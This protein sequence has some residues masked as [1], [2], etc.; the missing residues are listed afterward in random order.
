MPL[1][2]KILT[3]RTI[4]LDLVVVSEVSLGSFA[5]SGIDSSAIV[6]LM[7]RAG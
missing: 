6:V 5:G 3:K 2:F 7:L 4:V 1:P